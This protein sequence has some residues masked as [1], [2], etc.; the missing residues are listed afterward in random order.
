[1]DNELT[2][3]A[4]TPVLERP[5]LRQ[6]S[7]GGYVLLLQMMLRQLMF[8]TGEISGNFDNNTSQGVRAFQSNNRLT[9]D[10]IVG[11]DTW[12][13][14][15][16]LYSPLAIC[17]AGFH[18]VQPGETLWGIARR[19]NISVEQLIRIN[20]LSSTLLSV[21]QR[22]TISGTEA[23]EP[24][25]ETTTYIV[26]RGDNLWS[27]ARRFNTTVSNLKNLNNLTSDNL[28]I[29]QRLMVPISE[30]IP[31]VSETVYTVQRGDSLWSIA[32]KFNTTVSEL[33]SYNN[34]TSNLLSI[35]QR[36]RIPS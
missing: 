8:Y 30:I 7:Q 28:S 17:E 34:L 14:L 9:V 6:G 35:G 29:G 36:L 25:E 18:I 4:N 27:I 23:T 12:S 1:M 24:S 5:I 19:Y 32:R 16:Y 26:Q 21:G 33:M 10:G 15:T 3:L 22:L 11:R 2:L 20:N 31:P 13:S